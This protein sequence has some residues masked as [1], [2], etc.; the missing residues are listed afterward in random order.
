MSK[1]E[2]L[3]W[4]RIVKHLSS[5]ATSGEG[6]DAL[7]ETA[8]LATANDA[9]I[10]FRITGQATEV[11]ERGERPFMESLDLFPSWFI[12]LEKQSQLKA[13]E[14]KDARLFFIEA[15]TLQKILKGVSNSWAQEQLTKLFEVKEPLSAIDQLITPS[16]E[17]RVDASEK[18]Y[19]LHNE[20]KNLTQKI[21]SSL[22]ALVKS[23]DN[24]NILQDKFVTNREGRWVIPVKSGMRHDL[25][26]II[27]ATS[28]SKQTVFM[29]PQA[30]VPLNN[31]LKQVEAEIDDEIDR[32][33]NEISQYLFTLLH[34]I[35]T[36]K[37]VLLESDICFARAQ[38]AITLDAK[39]I[40]FSEK[41]IE[42]N[43]VKHPLMLINGEKVIPNSVR[44]TPTERILLLSGPNAGGK[45]V[46]LKCIGLA[47]Q[48]A[49]C[50]LLVCTE[51]SS[52]LPFFKNII[53]AVGDSQSVDSQLSTFVGHLQALNQACLVGGP[54]SLVL[55]DEICGSTD[56]EEGS[57]LARGFINYYAKM[58]LYG[59]ITSHLGPLKSG[60]TEDSGVINGSME[61]NR[62]TGTSTYH[63]IRGIPGQ[64]L[65]F[66][67]AKRI[68]VIPEV[69]HD[70]QNFLS[71]ETRKRFET[72]DEIEKAKE[73]ILI[74]RKE[75]KEKISATEAEKLVL[76]K[77]LTEFEK[78][79]DKR[80]EEEVRKIKARLEEETQKG[81]V[82]KIFS[83]H[84]RRS[85]IVTDFPEIVKAPK[86][87]DY[88]LDRFARA[89]PPGSVVYVPTLQ[90]DAIVQGQPSKQGEVPI[91]AGSMRLVLQ[92]DQLKPPKK[93]T[94]P[95]S[96][97]TFQTQM[98]VDTIDK[99]D[100]LD[101]R[102]KNVNQAIEELEKFIDRALTQRIDRIRIIHGHGSEALKKSIRS[103]LSRSTYV[104][105]WSSSQ[106]TTGDDGITLAYIALE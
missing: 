57:A 8:P 54:D 93:A 83:D 60:W 72:L 81:N 34:K 45:T 52:R 106:E 90:R 15:L 36:A 9:Q 56:P 16:A 49:R 62:E 82:D 91:L 11:L 10:L 99:G 5:F 71:P 41:D 21:Q 7:L 63:F 28:A 35:Q 51:K 94:N 98:Y 69:F 30:I 74:L 37:N 61:Y 86:E 64:S 79:R 100:T 103:H 59:I 43:N 32:L 55:I 19:N 24:E 25:P 33:L 14:L 80:L 68:G 89:F 22:N 26:G 73:Q 66:S 105:R 4:P 12:R 46:L 40:E 75:L 77:K 67:T 29:E 1:L 48:M 78:D 102:G 88:T 38:F 27:H 17:I 87:E 96:K 47:A 70:A 3:D 53:V 58:G 2:N 85:S 95:L 31:Q 20:K 39:P 13:L 92:W 44:L 42:L 97:R 23:H 18:L 65:A 6:K 104:N 84:E 101:V 50:G 76:K